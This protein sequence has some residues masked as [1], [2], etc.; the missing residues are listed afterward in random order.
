MR[1]YLHFFGATLTMSLFWLII[2]SFGGQIMAAWL[3]SIFGV[4]GLVILCWLTFKFLIL[5]KVQ[6][7]RELDN[8]RKSEFA[9]K[10]I[11]KK[12]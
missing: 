3:A 2:Y 8:I 12:S 9:E 10:V 11:F 4:I 6:S 5:L 1:N 7:K